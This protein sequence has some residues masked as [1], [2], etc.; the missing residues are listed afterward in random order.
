MGKAL[1]FQS[2]VESCWDLYRSLMIS[3]RAL[4]PLLRKLPLE[5]CDGGS[6]QKWVLPVPDGGKSLTVCAFILMQYWSVTDRQTN[7]HSD[8]P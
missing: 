3:G 8:L 1:D 2:V 6:T 4:M 7:R 5:L